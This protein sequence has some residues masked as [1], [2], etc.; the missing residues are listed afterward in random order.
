M[1]TSCLEPRFTSLTSFIKRVPSGEA[2]N[3]DLDK[4]TDSTFFSEEN[5]APVLLHLNRE[6][7]SEKNISKSF[8]SKKNQVAKKFIVVRFE[9]EEKLKKLYLKKPFW[10]KM[11]C[12]VA[13]VLR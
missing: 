10:L 13:Q 5:F 12:S 2:R 7:R 8:W 9:T 11:Y 3:F 4:K 1:L 6:V